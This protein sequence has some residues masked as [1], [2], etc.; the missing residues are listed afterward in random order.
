[1]LKMRQGHYG[2]VATSMKNSTA[3]LCYD[4][5]NTGEGGLDK[6]TIVC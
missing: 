5:A 3:A 6:P 2:V 4:C 1:M